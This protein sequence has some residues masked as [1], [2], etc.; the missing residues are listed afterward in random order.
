VTLPCHTSIFHS[1]PPS[2]HGVQ[3]NEWRAM[4]RPVTGRVDH[5]RN[6]N[7]KSG[8]IHNWEPF[9]DLNR[10][11]SLYYSFFINTGYQLDGDGIITETAV[12]QLMDWPHTGLE[13]L[14]VYY[15]TIDLAGHVYGWME[16]GY[17][18]QAALVDSLFGQVVAAAPAEMTI[19]AH[20]DHG[21]HE[22][23]HGDDIPEDM[24]I[25]W[26]I[27][28]PNV[29]ENYTITSPVS[30]LDTAPTITH[31]LGLPP[32]PEWEGQPVREAFIA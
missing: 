4:A 12:Q 9:R 15:S 23:N 5:L 10:V 21:G 26:M 3:S 32:V 7:K 13:F 24:T 16:Q 19:I 28:G 17:L 29:R 20:A 8:Y 2:R 22:R 18:E 25:P 14:F 1:V 11:G 6:N 27:A 31:I 30:L